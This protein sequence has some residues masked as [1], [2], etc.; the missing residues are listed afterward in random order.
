LRT[1]KF[2][3]H[4]GS[5]LKSDEIFH[6]KEDTKNVLDIGV[7]TTPSFLTRK[8]KRRHLLKRA[9]K[10]ASERRN[11]SDLNKMPLLVGRH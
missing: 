4:P 11:P 9:R 5:F 2:S 7:N 3:T 8:L 10:V 6:K 1:K